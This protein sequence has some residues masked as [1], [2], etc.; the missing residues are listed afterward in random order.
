M[1][2]K[3]KVPI[4]WHLAWGLMLLGA[5]AAKAAQTA[6]PGKSQ[7]IAMIVV[8]DQSGSMAGPKMELAKE[9]AKTALSLLREKDFFGVLTFDYNYRWAVN[10]AEVRDRQ[11]MR[12]AIDRIAASG[13]TNIYPALR[14]AY[15]RLK[16]TAAETKHIVL[17]SD[18]QTP[19]ENFEALASEMLSNKITVSTVAVTAASDRVLMAN[20]AKWGGG[21]AY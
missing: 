12:E 11:P 13:N 15:E 16:M 10:I 3:M 7:S 4:R 19:M 9:G 20:I 5:W 14:E 17:L 1:A 21:R 8:L 18:G 2:G 6:A